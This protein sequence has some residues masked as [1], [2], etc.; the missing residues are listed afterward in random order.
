[1]AREVQL[2]AKVKK[3]YEEARAVEAEELHNAIVELIDE[4]KPSLENALFVL[5]IIRFS[6]MEAKYK[7]IMGFVKLTD[8]PPLKVT[9]TKE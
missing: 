5:D 6:L 2:L 4:H 3:A 7:E 1:M 9:G 8:K